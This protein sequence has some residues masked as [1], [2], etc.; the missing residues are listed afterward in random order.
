MRQDVDTE[1]GQDGGGDPPAGGA[2]SGPLVDKH[3][4]ASALG[5]NVRT[6]A[7]FQDE[8]MPVAFRGRGGRASK[9][10]LED[11]RDW[12]AARNGGKDA[13]GPLNFLETRARKEMAQARLAEQAF[14][15]KAGLLVPVEQIEKTWGDHVSAVR[16]LILATYTTA[17]ARIQRAA[18]LDGL[19]GTERE[20]KAL[21]YEILNELATGELPAKRPRAPKAKTA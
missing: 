16:T 14:E 2:S 21:A 11:C 12:L 15:I 6:I 3:A 9:Y 19:A 10:D 18:T 8:G 1:D 20:L 17:A 4:L 13:A 7:K 5:V